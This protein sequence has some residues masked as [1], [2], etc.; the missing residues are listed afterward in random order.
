VI[1]RLARRAIEAVVAL[2]A[3]LG[4]CCVPLG[5]KT[6]LEHAGAV[7]RTDAALEAGRELV[8]AASGL[9]RRIFEQLDR[10]PAEATPNAEPLIVAEP[11]DAGSMPDASVSWKSAAR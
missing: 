4:F 8:D 5:Q 9:R 3:L 10:P 7:L 1:P 11:I 6:A 2:F